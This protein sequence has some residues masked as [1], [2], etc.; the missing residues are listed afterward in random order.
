MK[1]LRISSHSDAIRLSGHF[2]RC[3]HGASNRR[4]SIRWPRT[5]RLG[6]L[7]CL[8]GAA[9]CTGTFMPPGSLPNPNSAGPLKSWFAGGIAG[10]KIV[11]WGNS[12]V[13]N[14]Y[15][16]FNDL[17]DQTASRG[18]LSGLEY[19]RDMEGVESDA[20]G[21]VTVTLEAPVKYKAGQWV[22]PRFTD[23]LDNAIYW[24]PSVQIKSVH[25][26]TFT[27][28]LPRLGKTSY[29]KDNGQVTG[30]ILNF[31]NNGATLRGMLAGDVL[32]PASLVCSEKPDLLIIRG[33]LINDV[34]LGR[35]NLS[36]AETLEKEALAQFRKCIPNAAILLTT[37]NSLLTTD[38]GEHWVQPNANAQKY[39][40]IMHD[41]VMAMKG[42]YANVEVLDVMAIVYGTNCPASSP[43]M[44][45]QL[46][47]SAKGQH[48]ESGALLDVIGVL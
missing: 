33:P 46:H 15:Q 7:A 2:K 40:N 25:G 11:Y 18:L 14:A 12:T 21:N 9:G 17:G 31:G 3:F 26:N 36:Q 32:Y 39:T 29:T 4:P 42:I 8:L 45:N 30:S 20:N 38:T 22:S 35:R 47:P 27:Y 1:S 13:S 10:K 6:L 37:E 44:S 19:R 43:L 41:A 5:V 16:M 34:R 28:T 48:K 24:R 23:P